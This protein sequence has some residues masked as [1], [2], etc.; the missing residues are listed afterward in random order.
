M[1]IIF[2][3]PSHKACLVSSIPRKRLQ[4][5][6]KEE[7]LGKMGYACIIS[8]SVLAGVVALNRS[9]GRRTL[10]DRG[11]KNCLNHLAQSQSLVPVLSILKRNEKGEEG[12]KTPSR[13]VA[14]SAK[15]NRQTKQPV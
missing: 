11:R 2:S 13:N 9:M 6:R 12:I 8:L 7:I 1:L 4:R 14:S 10:T 3:T 15:E 5:V